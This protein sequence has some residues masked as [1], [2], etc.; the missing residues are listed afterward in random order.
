[1]SIVIT[2]VLAGKVQVNVVPYSVKR[3]A[4]NWSRSLDSQRRRWFGHKPAGRLPLPSA[5]PA[6]SGYS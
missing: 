2:G 4:R 3:K 5:R 6:L 1:M